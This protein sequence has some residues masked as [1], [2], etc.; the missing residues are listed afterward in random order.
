MSVLALTGTAV[1]EL[2][3]NYAFNAS[4]SQ[5]DWFHILHWHSPE[6]K[7]LRQAHDNPF[8]FY[9]LKC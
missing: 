6:I 3:C 7:A 9:A 4:R 2:K 1:F 8:G 5:D